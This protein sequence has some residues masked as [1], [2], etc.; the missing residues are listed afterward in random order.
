MDTASQQLLARLIRTTRTAALATLHEGEPNLAMVAFAFADDFS[1]FYIHV[2]RLGKH[3]RDMEI[4]RHVSPLFAET[5]DGRPDPGTLAR[6]S[7]QGMA[8]IVS[9]M[10]REYTE[11]KHLYLAHFPESE[12]LFSLGDFNLWRITPTGGRLVAGFARAFNL[13]PEALVNAS[14]L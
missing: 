7:L 11:I 6:V 1:V 4:D 9:K 5:D 2:S 14:R 13:V 10:D 8:G 3:T 12:S